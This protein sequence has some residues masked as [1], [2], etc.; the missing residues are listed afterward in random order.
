[1]SQMLKDRFGPKKSGK[2]KGLLF[3]IVGSLIALALTVLFIVLTS[4]L[5]G[6]LIEARHGG[7][8]AYA[9]MTIVTPCYGVAM[10]LF[11]AILAVWYIAPSESEVQ[12]KSRGLS[13]MLGQS[14]A[15]AFSKK[16]LWII[17]AAL[18]AGVLMTGLVAVNT[19]KLVTPDGFSSYFFLRVDHHG[20]D[21]VTGYAV[22]CDSDKGLT[23]TFTTKDAKK[24]EILSGVVSTT[25]A[26][27]EVYDST[28]HFADTIHGRLQNASV[29]CRVSTSAYNKAVKFY[30][31]SEALWGYV[32]DI[33]DY[34]EILPEPDETLPETDTTVAPTE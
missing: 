2:K 11:Y 34:A 4:L 20:W 16:K 10:M 7:E 28:L 33:I 18:S 25:K 15:K 21:E 9:L 30:R 1:M 6:V 31:N 22:D 8:V 17:T 27:D 3:L 32:A 12:E 5:T 24:T 23:M 26:F 13:P 19:Y 14:E 29:P